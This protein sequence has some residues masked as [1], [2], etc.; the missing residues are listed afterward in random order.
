MAE[1]LVLGHHLRR[2]LLRLSLVTK[3]PAV[4]D[5]SLTSAHAEISDPK[6]L[7]AN[8]RG[9]INANTGAHRGGHGNFAQI[10]AL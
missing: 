9:L 5:D 8:Q 6:Y 10:L 1:N 7:L 2:V 4:F 3:A